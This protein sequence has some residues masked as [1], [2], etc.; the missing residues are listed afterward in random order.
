MSAEEVFEELMTNKKM[1]ISDENVLIVPI[2]LAY[3]NRKIEVNLRVPL[4]INNIN[5]S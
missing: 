5:D 2:E 3:K 4:K 1:Q